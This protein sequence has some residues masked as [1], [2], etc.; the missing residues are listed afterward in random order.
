MC[1]STQDSLNVSCS[2]CGNALY[3]NMEAT[4]LAHVKSQVQDLE[5][6]LRKIELGEKGKANPYEHHDA[7]R[8]LVKTLKGV[9]YLPGMPAYLAAVRQVMLP[10]QVRLLENTMRANLVFCAILA[11]FALLPM[12]LGWP[13]SVTGLMLMPALVWVGVTLRAYTTLR[14]AR[15]ELTP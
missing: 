1:K 7:A 10:Y 8:Q 5:D 13:F 6:R 15:A 14:K 2:H 11:G 12:A 4:E 3:T 9:A